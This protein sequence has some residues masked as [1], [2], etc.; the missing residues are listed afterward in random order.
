MLV[1]GYWLLLDAG[2]WML[3]F[4]I[5]RDQESSIGFPFPESRFL[6][7]REAA[8]LA[9]EPGENFSEF[10]IDDAK[11]SVGTPVGDIPFVGVVMLHPEF[12][13]LGKD[14]GP[15]ILRQHVHARAA[16]GGDD[17]QFLRDRFEQGGHKWTLHLLEVSKNAHFVCK[18]FLCAGAPESFVHPSV[19]AEPD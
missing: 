18:S 11:A 6:L 19:K 16:T 3:G 5:I 13:Q 10:K 9:A 2:C 14:F 7:L 15:A 1:T 12:L 17:R 4:P 8:G